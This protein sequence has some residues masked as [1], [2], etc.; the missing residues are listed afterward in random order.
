[1]DKA[2]NSTIPNIGR[3]D[4]SLEDEIR[5]YAVGDLEASEKEDVDIISRFSA[6]VLT[7][8]KIEEY[9]DN[10]ISG[11]NLRAIYGDVLKPFMEYLREQAEYFKVDMIIDFEEKGE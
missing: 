3:V 4:F 10:F 8:E 1:M 6:A 2:V 5:A 11:K 9:L 7:D